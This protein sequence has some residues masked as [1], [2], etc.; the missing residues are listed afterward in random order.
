LQVRLKVSLLGFGAAV[1]VATTDTKWAKK[2]LPD[3]DVIKGQ[4]GNAK[5]RVSAPGVHA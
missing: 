5:K 1:M 4:P 2:N 3:P